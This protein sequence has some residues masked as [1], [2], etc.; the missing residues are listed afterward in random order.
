MS[1]TADEIDETTEL[2]SWAPQRCHCRASWRPHGQG[3]LFAWMELV[4]NPSALYVSGKLA[5]YFTKTAGQFG[6]RKLGVWGAAR[7]IKGKRC[8]LCGGSDLYTGWSRVYIM[9][10]VLE[11][12]KCSQTREILKKNITFLRFGGGNPNH[13]KWLFLNSDHQSGSTWH[14]D[15]IS[16]DTEID[17]GKNRG[18]QLMLVSQ[19]CHR[20]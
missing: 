13:L 11:T 19:S 14:S 3:L 12:L 7:S 15:I 5:R 8:I 18:L 2:N 16:L 9:C 6:K 4:L 17:G 10:I 1:K 20:G